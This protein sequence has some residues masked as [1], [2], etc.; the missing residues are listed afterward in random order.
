[1]RR[2]GAFSKRCVGGVR[3]DRLD[4]ARVDDHGRSDRGVL[5]MAGGKPENAEHGERESDVEK[6]RMEEPLKEAAPNARRVYREGKKLN[7]FAH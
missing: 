5:R 7:Q 4:G 6:N 3:S 2:T 1:M